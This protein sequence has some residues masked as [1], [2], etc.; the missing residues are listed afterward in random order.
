MAPATETPNSKNALRDSLAAALRAESVDL[1]EDDASTATGDLLAYADDRSA[2]LIGC[3]VWRGQKELLR[4]AQRVVE[5][6]AP[7]MEAVLIYYADPAQIALVA[8]AVMQAMP[9][10]AGFVAL[11][12]HSP[13][14]L[15]CCFRLPGAA[16]E[17]NLTIL[18]PA[19]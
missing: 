16:A 15:D 12:A 19:G 14:R 5:Q 18:L 8:Q 17:A 2:I 7:G 13:G 11:Q 9:H 1:A 6:L 3:D 10:Q 4:Q